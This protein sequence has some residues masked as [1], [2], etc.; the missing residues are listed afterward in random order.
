VP[1]MRRSNAAM[2]SSTPRRRSASAHAR[3]RRR[4]AL[5]AIEPPQ[6]R[7]AA[8][9]PRLTLAR[10]PDAR[11]RPGAL[12]DARAGPTRPRLRHVPKRAVAIVLGRI[13]DRGRSRSDRRTN[14]VMVRS[15][16]ALTRRSSPR[17]STPPTARADARPRR[18]S[19]KFPLATERPS[20]G[21]GRARRRGHPSPLHA[22]VTSDASKA[23]GWSSCS[24][25]LEDGAPVRAAARPRHR[26]RSQRSGRG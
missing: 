12:E 6:R 10:P 22:V 17:G 8:G 11:A 19:S 25:L 15:S 9:P 2:P 20:V 7:C 23:P 26:R 14:S 16:T 24:P 1:W 4:S 21:V 18:R 3:R 13:H 5:D